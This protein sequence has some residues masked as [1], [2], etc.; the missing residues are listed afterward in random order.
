MERI[1]AA[2][3]PIVR[4]IFRN[5]TTA[6]GT[7][8]V[9]DREELLSAF[10]DRAAAE[11]VADEAD[12]RAAPDLVGDGGGRGPAGAAPRRDRPRVAALGVAA[13][14]AL[15]D[16]GRRRGAAARPAPAGGAP[17]G[18]EGQGRG[19]ALD[20]IVVPRLPRLARALPGQA[21][22]ARGGLLGI[23]EGAG[24]A[25][26]AQE[27]HGRRLRRRGAGSRAR[28]HGGALGTGPGGQKAGRGEQAPRAG[29]TRGRR[30]PRCGARVC[31][32]EPRAGR[33]AGG[34]ALRPS[35]HR[36]RSGRERGGRRRE[37]D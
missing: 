16:A 28:R 8:A 9:L 12:R 1:G 35:R 6:Q 4:E 30:G 23:D 20:G 14:R 37:R 19:P 26:E 27:A 31:H 24:G 2:M 7:R 11:A 3:E 36:D 21:V 32:E 33:H 5:L 17:V 34:P 18:G 13:P 29:P 15:A 10:P 22:V 25:Q